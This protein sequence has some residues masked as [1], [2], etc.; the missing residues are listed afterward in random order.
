M[1]GVGNGFRTLALVLNRLERVGCDV[2]TGARELHPDASLGPNVRALATP[3]METKVHRPIAHFP[4]GIIFIM[5]LFT[6]A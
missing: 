4:K 2:G 6:A 5:L 1:R 3:F